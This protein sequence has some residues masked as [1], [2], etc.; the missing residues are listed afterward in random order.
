MV[1]KDIKI[2]L[3]NIVE[4]TIGYS[5]TQSM[6]ANYHEN[7]WRQPIYNIW[8]IQMNCLITNSVINENTF[9]AY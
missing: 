8:A 2:V 6:F 5:I 9:Y 7:N 3:P 4:R 1:N